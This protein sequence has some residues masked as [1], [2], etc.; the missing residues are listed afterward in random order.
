[1]S[2]Q[3][4]TLDKP[5]M[6]LADERAINAA[7]NY[8]ASKP[9]S[10]VCQLINALMESKPYEPYEPVSKSSETKSVLKKEK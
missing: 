2:Q 8:L 6:F 10:E 5:K 4:T 3:H 1:M 7:I 9:Y